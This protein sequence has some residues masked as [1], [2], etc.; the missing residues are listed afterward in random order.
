MKLGKI[1]LGASLM[2]ATATFAQDS[3]AVNGED[4][5][6]LRMR[7]IANDAME[8]KDYKESVTYFIKGETICGNY[9]TANYGRLTGSLMRLIN[10]EQDQELKYKYTDTLIAVWDRMDEKGLYDHKNDMSRG[11]YY[12][13]LNPA[14]YNKADFFLTRGVKEQ[15]TSV[16]E[17]Y[18]ASFYYNT[19]TL[20]YIEQDADKKNALKKRMITDYFSL[21]KLITEANFSIKTQESLTAYLRTV[22]QSCDDL[23]PEIADFIANLSEDPA[24]AT[25]ALM[26]LITLMEEME[27]TESQEYMDLINKYLEID[28]ESPIALEMKA[29]ILEKQ[30][31]YRDANAI[32]DKLIGLA[33]VTDERKAE[34]KY[35][36][37]ANVYKTGAY[38]A[39]YSKAMAI[40]GTNRSKALVIA[41]QCVA[42]TA[43]SCGESTFL[44]KCNYIYAV[45]LLEKAGQGG[46]SQANKY[47]ANYPTSD[48]CFQEGNPASVTL[49]CWGVSVSPCN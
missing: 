49:E 35:K 1:L 33:E 13:Q 21:S 32:Y 36:I 38:K 6:C 34:L 5:E 11:L 47:K 25:S 37:V 46:S 26:S 2:I 41:A 23:T 30:K 3:T 39:A 14:D 15:G 43:N 29:K 12:L 9:T 42:A 18:I 4:R 17:N 40:Q 20:F 7:K 24:A 45:Q 48:M 28:P 16:K 31:K 27:C 10:A 22:V 19:Y 44:R 8:I